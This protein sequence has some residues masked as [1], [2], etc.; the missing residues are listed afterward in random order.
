[1][2]SKQTD[3]YIRNGIIYV[4]GMVKGEYKRYSTGKKDTKENLN[5]I[6]KNAR[7]ELKRIHK[8]KASQKV[9][10]TKIE[11]P[12]I[13]TNF[14]DYSLMFFELKKHKLKENTLKEYLS[15]FE[16]CILPY[17]KN[18]DLKDIT[19]IDLKQW[20][21]ELVQKGMKG[22]TINNYRTVFNSILEE[23]RK[24]GLIEK[25]FFST[26]DKEKVTK[27]LIEPFSL[28]EVKLILEN[29]TGVE[30]QFFQISFFTGMRTGELL[31]LKWDD[32]NF[33]SKQIHIKRAIRRGTISS[34]KTDGSVRVIDM[35]PIVEDALNKLKFKSYMKNSF[36]FLNSNNEPFFDSSSIRDGEW[37]RA[38][39]RAKLD[40]RS[41]Y[42]TR[43]TFTSIMISKG[44][45]I[46]WVSKMLGHSN[47]QTTLTRYAKFIK[48]DKTKRATFLENFYTEIAQNAQIK[49]SSTIGA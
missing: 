25:N 24:D 47:M 28:D 1:M 45:D 48:S 46:L 30:K 26:I 38:L 40:Y 15:Q 2:Q 42:H 39:K 23:A 43:H 8:L 49:Q 17:F 7:L 14:L 5:Y 31:A 3:F 37:R 6:K 4:Q 9:Q 18:H 44:E 13:S 36:I 32:I 27:P 41:L 22:K 10:E 19:R 29:S 33:V 20:Q 35:L 12:T 34:P 16:K 21:N 11:E